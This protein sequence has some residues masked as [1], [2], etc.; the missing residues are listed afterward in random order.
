L[1]IFA[2]ALAACRTSG[3]KEGDY[4]DGTYYNFSSA[5][6]VDFTQERVFERGVEIAK[7][8]WPEAD[9]HYCHSAATSEFS[10]EEVK[11]LLLMIELGEFDREHDEPEVLA[12]TQDASSAVM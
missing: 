8:K 10:A 4:P 2:V 1:K 9:G 3:S 5:I 6:I 12:V 11:G 7:K